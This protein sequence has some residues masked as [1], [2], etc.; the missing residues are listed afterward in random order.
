MSRVD[1]APSS[2][3][4]KTTAVSSLPVQKLK[5][6]TLHYQASWKE[7]FPWILEI[8]EVGVLCRIWKT[9]TDQ[10]LLNV[11]DSRAENAFV[12]HGFCNWKKALISFKKHENSATHTFSIAQLEHQSASQSIGTQ[13]YTKLC[14]DRLKAFGVLMNIISSVRYLARQGLALRGHESDVGSA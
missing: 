10:E 5:N 13:L 6:K 3:T 8:P 4:A 2:S 9:T 12:S 7:T 14:S 1:S 11:A